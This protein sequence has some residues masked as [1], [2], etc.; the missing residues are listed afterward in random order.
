[1]PRGGQG[2]LGGSDA[3]GLAE[4]GDVAGAGVA[5]HGVWDQQQRV[6]AWQLEDI[7]VAQ[8]GETFEV[9]RYEITLNAVDRVQGPNYRS[10]M[11][12]LWEVGTDHKMAVNAFGKVSTAFFE[13]QPWL[14]F[15]HG[16]VTGSAACV[17]NKEV[18]RRPGHS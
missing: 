5:H 18:D 13:G 7:R 9:G 1:M 11:V 15:G 10:T 8:V 6:V 14:G 17:F 2:D 3:D 4:L 16:V 12:P